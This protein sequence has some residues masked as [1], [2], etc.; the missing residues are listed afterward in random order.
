MSAFPGFK[1]IIVGGGPV[2]LA[3]GHC[4]DKAGIDFVILERRADP[5]LNGGASIALWPQSARILDQI[6]LLDEAKQLYAP[7]R[8][9]VNVL[10]DGTVFGRNDLYHKVQTLYATPVLSFLPCLSASL[11]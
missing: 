9:K 1:V 2:G 6:G 3:A 8:H 4:L 10:R 5:D 7:I 11:K